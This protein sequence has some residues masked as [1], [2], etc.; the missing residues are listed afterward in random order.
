MCV[1]EPAQSCSIRVLWFCGALLGL[2]QLFFSKCQSALHVYQVKQI[3]LK[4]L[5]AY[6]S[7]VRENLL[8][9]S[10][11]GAVAFPLI[12]SCFLH[13]CLLWSSALQNPIYFPRLSLLFALSKT[14]CVGALN[15]VMAVNLK[16]YGYENISWEMDKGNEYNVSL[17][18]GC[19]LGVLKFFN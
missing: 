4:V 11:W 16:R 17:W 13:V 3:S 5:L 15:Q 1:V 8:N 6:S 7:A 19:F 12:I 14:V 10:Q 18:V 2:N 9:L